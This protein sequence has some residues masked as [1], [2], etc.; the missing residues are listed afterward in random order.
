MVTEVG[1]S[2]QC[3]SSRRR[4]GAEWSGRR[5]ACGQSAQFSDAASIRSSTWAWFASTPW[6]ERQGVIGQ[7]P[8]LNARPNAPASAASA[9]SARASSRHQAQPAVR[10]ARWAISPSARSCSAPAPSLMRSWVRSW[11]LGAIPRATYAL[12]WRPSMYT[13]TEDTGAPAWVAT[14]LGDGA[15]AAGRPARAARSRSRRPRAP[16]RDSL[17]SS[18]ICGLDARRWRACSPSTERSAARGG[19]SPREATPSTSLAATETM[20]STT[21]GAMRQAVDVHLVCHSTSPIWVSMKSV[22]ASPAK[23]TSLS[24]TRLWNGIV[25]AIPSITN[26][27]K[28]RLAAG[29]TRLGAILA[30]H[31]HLGHERVVV[32]RD[33]G[34]GA[35]VGLHAHA[36][37]RRGLEA[38]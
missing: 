34:T 35:Q 19:R 20:V 23:N 30:V 26:S 21:P 18:P 22:V 25:V 15:G 10:A 11:I 12:N 8:V 38:A 3:T 14:R 36:G 27:S 4:P 33:A 13:S 37:A 2:S 29:R 17:P 16:P 7:R 24:S 1:T 6:H 31:D 32:G 9:S 5:W 28:A